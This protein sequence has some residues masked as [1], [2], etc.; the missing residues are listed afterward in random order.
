MKFHWGHGIFTFYAFFVA[1]LIVVVVK[2]TG[3][4]NS[5]VTEEYYARDINY[6]QEYDRRLN[7]NSLEQSVIIE[8]GESGMNL[9]FPTFQPVEGTVLFYRPSSKDHD[10]RLPITVNNGNMPLDLS[11]LKF[12]NYQLI[13]EWKSEGVS[14]Y[15]ELDLTVN[16]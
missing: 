12:G 3:F 9:R 14:Y 13:V 2:S 5:L 15:D 1:T 7:S 11:G 10:Q 6:Q 16:P 8:R 4:D